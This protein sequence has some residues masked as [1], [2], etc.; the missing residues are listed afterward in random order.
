MHILKLPSFFFTNNTS[1]SHG[2]ELGLMKP[3]SVSSC[4]YFFNSLNSAE[5]KWYGA[6]EMG[7]AP[8]TRS[9]PNSTSRWGGKSENSSGKTSTNS[10]MIGT[11]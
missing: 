11:S 2:D 9:M 8:R 10:L 6:L 3:L 5:D 1:A 7:V 4:N